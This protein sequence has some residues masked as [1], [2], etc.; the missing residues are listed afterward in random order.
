MTP[1]WRGLEKRIATTV[2][3]DGTMPPAEFA[4]AFEHAWKAHFLALSL[5]A[6]LARSKAAAARKAI[7]QLEA[8]AQAA[9]AEL[10]EL[11]GGAAG[12]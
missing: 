12:R 4:K 8:E 10:A 2:D 11:G 9:D 6:S 5:R 1:A 3:P 7:P